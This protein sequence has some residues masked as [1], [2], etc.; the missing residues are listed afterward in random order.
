M[1]RKM[2]EESARERQLS[3]AT[4]RRNREP[5]ATYMMITAQQACLSHCAFHGSGHPLKML[6]SLSAVCLL[7]L[8]LSRPAHTVLA[9][10]TA[11]PSTL[12]SC[13]TN[14]HLSSLLFLN[15]F[16][17]LST[18]SCRSKNVFK[19]D[20]WLPQQ[21]VSRVATTSSSLRQAHDL[22]HDITST[23]NHNHHHDIR[24]FRRH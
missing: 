16:V 18:H 17:H 5:P 3:S 1:V 22:H 15:D 14:L 7:P 13:S 23:A 11:Q 8:I 20:F 2:G 10:L 4:V 6:R 19:M 24:V 9:L 21:L 12:V